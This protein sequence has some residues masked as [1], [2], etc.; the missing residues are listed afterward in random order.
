MIDRTKPDHDVIIIGGGPA[1]STAAC[2]LAK[3]GLDVLV[4]EREK[5]PRPHVG[6]SLV[7]ATTRVFKDIDFIGVMENSGFLRKYGAAWS[8]A[9]NKSIHDHDFDNVSDDYNVPDEYNV[10]IEF[11]ERS[12]M[13]GY[14][15]TYSYHVDRAKFDQLLLNHAAG[16][17]AHVREECAVLDF[18]V[19]AQPFVTVT[20]RSKDGEPETLTCRML[21]DASGRRTVIGNKLKIKVKDS[22]FDQHV[23]H[24]WFEDFP[25]D[26]KGKE[27]FIFI[28]FLPTTSAWV[29]QIPITDKI[30]SFGIVTPKKYFEGAKESR[31]RFFWQC[32]ES[33]PELAMKL[34]GAKQIRDF[35]VETDY[36]YS[37]KQAAGD[38]WLLIGD[39]ARFVDPIFSSGV[40]IAMNSAKF[41]CADVLAAAK[42][43]DYSRA[44]FK[45]YEQR[46]RWGC[47]NWYKFISVYYRLNVLFTYFVNHPKYRLEVIRLLSGD[48]YEEEEPAV[49]AKMRETVLEVE[50]NPKHIWHNLLNEVR[51][52]AF[53]E[54]FQMSMPKQ[55]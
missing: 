21:M 12:E 11:G 4:V 38:R 19:E 10:G 50:R 8:S 35:T 20:L 9:G 28:H 13:D 22:Q 37:C 26:V 24:T 46:V 30:T 48:V 51:S 29:W 44:S 23:I 34:R 52:D 16:F 27:E 18:D 43:G 1:G 25:R 53:G 15:Q 47:E 55:N 45:N 54:N 17:G 40:S 2:Y 41:A 49:I 33:R 39:A 3:G 36:S 7:P 6:E 31:E 14:G 32:V 42:T 5:F